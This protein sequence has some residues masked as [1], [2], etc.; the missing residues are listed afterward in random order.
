MKTGMTGEAILRQEEGAV[1]A[2]MLGHK[3]DW[4][5]ESPPLALRALMQCGRLGFDPWVGKIPW[6]RE[7]LPTPVFWPGEFHGL[8]SGITKSRT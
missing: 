6:K 8:Y 2:P 3:K 7:S 4:A 1:A 5:W